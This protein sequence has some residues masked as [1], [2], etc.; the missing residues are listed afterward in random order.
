MRY[1][2]IITNIHILRIRRLLLPLKEDTYAYK[3]TYIHI[4]STNRRPALEYCIEYNKNL[5]L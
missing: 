1:N 2:E 5:K 3:Y 4:R